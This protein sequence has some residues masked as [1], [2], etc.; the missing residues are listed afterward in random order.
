MNTY[1][2]AFGIVQ[3][4]FFAIVPLFLELWLERDLVTAVWE[5]VKLVCSFSWIFFL[6]TAQTK[7]FHFARAIGVGK[8]TPT[9]TLTPTPTLTLTLTP[10]PSSRWRRRSKN[11]HE[12]PSD[13]SNKSA[14]RRSWF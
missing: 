3:L 6:F 8:V 11:A 12:T 14:T 9:L 4:G 10:S 5:N 2:S 1:E 13:R 7:G